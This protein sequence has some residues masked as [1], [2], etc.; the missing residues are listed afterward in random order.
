[1][2][3]PVLKCHQLQGALPPDSP[4]GALPPGPPVGAPPQTPVIDSRS[5]P[6]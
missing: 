6:P 1:M 4:P 2:C 5:R 3:V